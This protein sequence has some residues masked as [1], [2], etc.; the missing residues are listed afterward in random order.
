[1]KVIPINQF[2]FNVKGEVLD[3]L[4]NL[5]ELSYSYR[6]FDIDKIPYAHAIAAEKY[7]DNSVEK[8]RDMSSYFAEF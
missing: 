6:E 5:E 1:M 2:E 3:G 8:L 4:V 7:R